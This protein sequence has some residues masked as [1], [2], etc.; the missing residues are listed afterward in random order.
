VFEAF[1]NDM[2]GKDT[3]SDTRIGEIQILMQ[4][5]KFPNYQWQWH[6][7]YR[8]EPGGDFVQLLWAD[9]RAGIE[10][11]IKGR[12]TDNLDYCETRIRSLVDQLLKTGLD[13]AVI[14]AA[15]ANNLERTTP[16]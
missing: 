12:I 10:P 11:A 4:G 5:D 15:M 14:A 2:P 8:E 6:S 13:R 7:T 3:Y 9:F 16:A 1:L